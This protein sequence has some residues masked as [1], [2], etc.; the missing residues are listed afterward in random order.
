MIV[1]LKTDSKFHEYVYVNK[2]ELL[3]DLFDVESDTG[4]TNRLQQS[5]IVE[6]MCFILLFFTSVILTLSFGHTHT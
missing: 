4:E 3:N 1:D 6:D 2:G 5:N